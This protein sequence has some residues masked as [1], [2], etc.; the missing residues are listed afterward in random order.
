[1]RYLARQKRENAVV[2][3]YFIQGSMYKQNFQVRIIFNHLLLRHA[4]R[5]FVAPSAYPLR[6]I[7][8]TNKLHNCTANY[9]TAA[10]QPQA[11]KQPQV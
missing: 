7:K 3:T 1:M 5:Q 4:C 8:A 9:K 6:N 2:L 10:I 11:S